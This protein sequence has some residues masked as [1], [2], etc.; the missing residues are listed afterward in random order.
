MSNLNLLLKYTREKYFLGKDIGGITLVKTDR[1]NTK[2]D[3]WFGR[4]LFSDVHNEKTLKTFSGTTNG[5]WEQISK[6][7]AAELLESHK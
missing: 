1:A 5:C 3:N 6:K 7:R 4:I 2:K